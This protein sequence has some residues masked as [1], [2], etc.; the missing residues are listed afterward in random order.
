MYIKNIW[1]EFE[2]W[3]GNYDENDEN[4][5]VHFELDDGRKWCSEFF[6]YQNL[7]SLS[8]KIKK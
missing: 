3:T 4:A 7:I 2:E 8:N 5:D 6:T 1:F